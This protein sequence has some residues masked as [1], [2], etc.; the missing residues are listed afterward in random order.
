MIFIC[1]IFGIRY[2]YD[3]SIILKGYFSF[4]SIKLTFHFERSMKV[5]LDVLCYGSNLLI[6][7]NHFGDDIKSKQNTSS[8]DIH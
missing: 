3:Q 6:Q 8:Q 4:I 2:I 1:F 7:H 5:Q